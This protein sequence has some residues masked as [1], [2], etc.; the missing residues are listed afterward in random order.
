MTREEAQKDAILRL[1][2]GINI[3]YGSVTPEI[4]AAWLNDACQ[5]ALIELLY[6]A[7]PHNLISWVDSSSWHYP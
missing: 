2:E 1:R 5:D 3:W 7:M 6:P 4:I